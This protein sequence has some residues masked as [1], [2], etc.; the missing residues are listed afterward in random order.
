MRKWHQLEKAYFG[1]SNIYDKDL[2]Y[3]ATFKKTSKK[4]MWNS[5][6]P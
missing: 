1:K 4:L 5:R 2:L 6:Q 3:N